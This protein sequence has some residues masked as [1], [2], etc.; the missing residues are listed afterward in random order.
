MKARSLITTALSAVLLSTVAACDE[1]PAEI[2]DGYVIAS[3]SV[4]QVAF[5]PADGTKV[6]VTITNHSAAPISIAPDGCQSLFDVISG[7]KTVVVDEDTACPAIYGS[8][9]I[10]P[11]ESLTNERI[12]YG[13][14]RNGAL[15]LKSGQYSLRGKVFVGGQPVFSNAIAVELLPE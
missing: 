9:L 6:R 10:K 13:A 3:L 2:S 14:D 12:W 1:N 4:S 15:H 5:R 11:G 7:T 8:Q